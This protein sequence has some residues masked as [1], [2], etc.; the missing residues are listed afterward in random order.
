[1][2]TLPKWINVQSICCC[3][4]T[5]RRAANRPHN[6]IFQSLCRTWPFLHRFDAYG[7]SS[8]S[9]KSNGILNFVMLDEGWCSGGFRG[10]KESVSKVSKRKYSESCVQGK[11]RTGCCIQC[12]LRA[13]GQDQQRRPARVCLEVHRRVKRN[14]LMHGRSDSCRAT[15]KSFPVFFPYLHKSA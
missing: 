13:T 1:M 8:K 14:G 11:E 7:W 2:S 6:L 5:L 9:G 10:A 3:R 12:L 15:R 4:N